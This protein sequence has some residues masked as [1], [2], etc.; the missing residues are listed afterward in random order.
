MPFRFLLLFHSVKCAYGNFMQHHQQAE[1]TAEYVSSICHLSISVIHFRAV[2]NKTILPFR[3]ITNIY[4]KE[5]TSEY[6]AFFFLWYAQ[7]Q[8]LRVLF[9]RSFGM[10]FRPA[11]KFPGV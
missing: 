2:P 1:K 11:R 4:H 9:G 3:S 5:E 8:F 10:V 6:S 7:K